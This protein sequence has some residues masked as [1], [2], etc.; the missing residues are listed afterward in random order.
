M[1]VSIADVLM[2]ITIVRTENW[3][4]SDYNKIKKKKIS[5]PSN[6]FSFIFIHAGLVAPWLLGL[7]SDKKNVIILVAIKKRV[8]SKKASEWRK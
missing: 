6:A 3:T 8:N 1:H 7:V 2:F 4:C 5:V